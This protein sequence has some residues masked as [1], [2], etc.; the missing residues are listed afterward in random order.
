MEN[1]ILMKIFIDD[2]AYII[3]KQTLT[4]SELRSIAKLD[5]SAELWQSIPGE[6]ND[7]FIETFDIIKI[8]DGFKFI[9]LKQTIGPAK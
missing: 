7:K 2:K 3:E 4:G 8:Q 6:S 5:G 9:S 1:N